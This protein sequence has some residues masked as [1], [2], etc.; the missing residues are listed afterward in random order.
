MELSTRRARLRDDLRGQ[1]RG[2]IIVDAPGRALYASDASLFQIDPLAVAVPV[3]EDDLRI[4]VRY[5]H[6]R[7]L[8]LV[9]RGAG[10]GLAGESLTHGIVVDLSVHFR[11]VLES[12]DDWVRVQPGVVLDR[13]N[14]ELARLGRRFAPDPASRM[15]C[16]IGGM[17]ATD[18]SGTRAAQHGYTRDHVLGLGVVWDDGSADELGQPAPGRSISPSARTSE[19]STGVQQLFTAHADIIAASRPRAPFNRC[20]YRLYDVSTTL[21]PN[22]VRLLIGSEGT[23]GLTTAATLRTIPLPAGRA[24]AAFGFPSFETAVQ[25]GHVTCQSMPTACEVL[26]RRLVS[27]ARLQSQGAAFAIPAEAE[28]VLIVEYERDTPVLARDAVLSLVTRLKAIFPADLFVAPAY[29]EAELD[30]LWRVRDAAVPALYALGKGPRPLPFVDDIGVHPADLPV[31]VERAQAVLKRLE[32]T[33]SFLIHSATGQVHLRPILDPDKPGDAAR[34]WP[35]AEELHSLALALGGTI[36]AQHGTGL[37]RTPWV[38]RQYA[39]LAPVFRELKGIFDPRGILNPGKIVGPD[40]SH[41]AWPLRGSAASSPPVTDPADESAASPVDQPRRDQ[42]PLLVWEPEELSKAITACNGCGA[43]RTEDSTRRMCPTFRAT[44]AESAAPRAKINLFRSLLESDEDVRVED[45]RAVADLCVNCKMCAT[46]CPGKANIPKLMLEAK[47]ANHARYGLRR[48][49]WLLARMDGL[50]ALAS[51]FSFTV[52]FLLRRATVRWALERL[53]GLARRR[54]LP[55][56]AFRSFMGRARRRGLTSRPDGETAVAYFVDT[57][58]NVFDPAIAEATVAVLRHNGVPVY[59]PARQRG[60]GAAALTQGDTDI[61]RERLLYNVRRLADAARAGDTIVC[62]EPTAAL[63]FRLD[64]L[65][66]SD[67][68]D[69]KAVAERT[70][71]LTAYLWSLHEQGRLRTD[72]QPVEE[73]AIGHHVPCHIKA[74]GQGVHGP[75]LL[76]LIPGVRVAKID[77]SCSGMAGTFGLSAKNLPLSLAAGRPMLDELARPEHAYGSSE[78]SAC[79]L[80]MQE[81][82]GKRALHPVQFLAM[83]YGLIPSFADRLRRPFRGRVSA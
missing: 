79:R 5:A 51:K 77:V 67:D 75:A 1:F 16:T 8:P 57:Y 61:A 26:D 10:T 23:L 53:F 32:V 6:D 7:S 45:V 38:E 4:L 65:G 46:E 13:L 60:C 41:P 15:S 78:C 48:S 36:S 21:A 17:I 81:G 80:Q 59:V 62:S 71:E 30:A 55:A 66:L 47:A 58:A 27:L 63:F 42:T 69:V 40:P 25:A 29:E 68:P 54:T 31:F 39:K 56:F 64:A 18:A 34:L 24:G 52:N 82:T 33:A 76:A 3:D 50:A 49:S 37:A 22:L 9:A 28:A 73:A 35:L 11:A 12:G 20:G 19:I 83:A 14:T 44:H 70:V 74:L 72:F 43:C 2:Q